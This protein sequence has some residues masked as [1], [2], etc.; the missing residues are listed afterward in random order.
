MAEI[1]APMIISPGPMTSERSGAHTDDAIAA[2]DKSKPA[3]WLV[4]L[5]YPI[6]EVPALALGV[7][8]GILEDVQLAGVRPVDLQHLPQGLPLVSSDQVEFLRRGSGRVSQRR[9]GG[10][11]GG[12]RILE[13]QKN[14]FLLLL[15][16]VPP[17]Q[18]H[19]R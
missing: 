15:L 12:G 5:F 17:F 1:Y 10:S 9:C 19:W 13:E 4:S 11:T 7:G 18:R 2:G 14:R 6:Q 8:G 3:G 16:P